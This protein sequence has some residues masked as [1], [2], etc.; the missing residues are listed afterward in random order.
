[1]D[2]GEIITL[3]TAVSDGD[4]VDGSDDAPVTLLEYGNFEC[5]DCGYAYPILK[6][7][8]KELGSN[9][10][11]V[12]RN[13]PSTRSNPNALRAAEAAEAAAAQARFWEMHDQLFEHQNALEDNH[14]KHYAG[15]AH[16]DVLRFE[17]DLNQHT[18][19]SQIEADYQS[20]LFDEHITGTPT[21]YINGLRYTGN[22]D[23]ES[24]VQAIKEAD[25]DGKI[26]ILTGHHGFKSL[27]SRFKRE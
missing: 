7:I 16:L 12:F 1:M 17:Q 21:L 22:I 19:L 5:V 26:E 6:H 18:F 3:K 10:R 27:I 13:F 11:F 20:S 15:L 8:R 9:L 25:T 2:E 24:M 14:L 4:H 23:L